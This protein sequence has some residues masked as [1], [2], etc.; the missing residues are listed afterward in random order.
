MLWRLVRIK[1][2]KEERAPLVNVVTL[3]I[4]G[5][6]LIAAYHVHSFLNKDGFHLPQV[7]SNPVELKR[8]VNNEWVTLGRVPAFTLS[9]INDDSAKLVRGVGHFIRFL[10]HGF[11][12]ESVIRRDEENLVRLYPRWNIPFQYPSTLARVEKEFLP[13]FRVA[14][15]MFAKAQ[16]DLIV[17]PVPMKIAVERF[18]L[19]M[20][21]PAEH[22]RL[23][24][25]NSEVEDTRG[26]YDLLSKCDPNHVLQ[27]FDLLSKYQEKRPTETLYVPLDPH[28]ASLSIAL[29][30]KEIVDRFAIEAGLT[31]RSEVHWEQ[32]APHIRTD[33]H[34]YG[35]AEVLPQWAFQ[36]RFGLE[37][38]E[39]LYNLKWQ[40]PHFKERRL[41]HLGSSYSE[42]LQSLKHDLGTLIR[43]VANVDYVDAVVRGGNF[44]GGFKVLN[45]RKFQ[46]RP[47][48]TVLWEIPVEYSLGSRNN[49]REVPALLQTLLSPMT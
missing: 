5:I 10:T 21:L 44:A 47:G 22:V 42:R 38:I 23:A 18:R 9:E 11:F 45:E 29:T 13:D 34:T 1:S 46:F 35:W 31:E 32:L 19:P 6:L 37:W 28:W 17:I 39:P 30:A 26:L 33:P 49:I 16:L 12:E 4:L 24:A 15:E 48:D 43:N 36:Q 40:G 8:L 25:A 3:P 14:L 20:P 27:I 7:K 41:V 2:R